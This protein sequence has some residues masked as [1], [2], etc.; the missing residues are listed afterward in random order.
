MPIALPLNIEHD[1]VEPFIES[2]FEASAPILMIID[3][4]GKWIG[5]QCI[6]VEATFWR[7]R[8]HWTETEIIE[9]VWG[10][11]CISQRLPSQN[12]SKDGG[13]YSGDDEDEEED[14][15]ANPEIGLDRIRCDVWPDYYGLVA[16]QQQ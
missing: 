1:L 10:K 6:V 9:C 13:E 7:K 2:A 5:Q 16:D 3:T 11:N 14:D 8:K 12:D 15:D 4:A